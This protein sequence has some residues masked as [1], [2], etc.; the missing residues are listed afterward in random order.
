[1]SAVLPAS[2]A[3]NA[4]LAGRAAA[5]ERAVVASSPLSA[6]ER[7]AASRA[8]LR[9]ALMNIAHPPPRASP[10]GGLSGLKEQIITRIRAMPGA[11][12]LIDT[13]EDWWARHPLH[14]IGLVAEEAARSFL[15]PVART[16]P[17]ALIV[18]SLVVGAVLVAS[19]PWKWLLKPAL[20]VGLVPQLAAHALRRMP[21]ESWMEMLS[22]ILPARRTAK[23]SPVAQQAPDLPMPP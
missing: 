18:G 8:R 14:A 15:L 9:S 5:V 4:E 23:D 17:F 16:N 22:S 13:L 19:R 12:F 10:F 7:L 1:M 2:A 20:F 11:D 6:T 21:V 3:A